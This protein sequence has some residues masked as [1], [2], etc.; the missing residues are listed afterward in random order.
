MF[1]LKFLKISQNTCAIESFFKKSCFIEKETLAQVFS[2]EFYETSPVVA[3]VNSFKS[4]YL[5]FSNSQLFA[6]QSTDFCMTKMSICRLPESILH[7]WIIIQNEFFQVWKFKN[8]KGIL[9]WPHLYLL[10]RNKV[11][12][13]VIRNYQNN[14][15]RRI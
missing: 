1:F 2:S 6:I 5:L 14:Y 11:F 15:Q 13:W 12:L 9:I 7:M 4:K 10:N 3:S 8:Q